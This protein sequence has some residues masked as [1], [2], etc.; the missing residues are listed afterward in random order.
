MSRLLLSI[1]GLALAVSAGAAQA[2]PFLPEDVVKEIRVSSPDIS[3]DG[4]RVVYEVT[5]ADLAKDQPVTQ[6]WIAN[7]DGSGTRQLTFREGFDHGTPKFSPDGALVGFLSSRDDEEEESRLWLLP[8]AGGEAYPLPN[9]AGSVEDF[10]F[11][12][13]GKQLALIAADPEPVLKKDSDD[14]EIPLPIVIDR[15]HFKV[16]GTGYLG[17]ERSR[18]YLYDMATGTAKRMTD[19]DFDEAFPAWS[20]DGTKVA[21]VSRRAPDPDRTPDHNIYLA[22]ADAPGTEPVRLT[23]SDWADAAPDFGSYPAWSPDGKEI[24]YVKGGDPELLW[25]AATSL[26]V[27]PA[28]GGEPRILTAGLDRNIYNPAWT[29]DGSAIRFVLED[30]GKQKLVAIPKAGG[31]LTTLVEG[32]LVVSSP[33]QSA[34]GRMA[35]LSS[36]PAVPFELFAVDGGSLRQLSRHNEAWLKEIDL[37]K[38]AYTSYKSKDG[39]EVRGFVMLPPNAERGEKLPTFLHPHGGPAMQYDYSFDSWQQVFA[40]AGYA[41]LTPNPRGSTG[42]GTT[43]SAG[44]NAAWGSVDVEDDLAA[45]DDAVAKGIADPDRLVVGGWSYGG[46]STNYLIASDTRFKA[47]MAGAGIANIFSGYGTD[48]YILEYELELGVPWDNLDVW[49]KNS[50]PFIQNTKIVTP[51][52]FMVGE[53]DVNVPT[54]A[55][56]QM[57]QALKSR[58]IDTT[59]V[60]YPDE[61]HGI[62][63]PSFQIDRMKRWLAWYAEHLKD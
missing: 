21:F 35:V 59:L 25:Y 15:Y 40:G 23:T 22:R 36:S 45:V 28:A 8:L 19:G 56:E 54:L 16:D 46:M 48:Q 32:E 55:S 20:P 33:A 17:K 26:A 44:I 58:G 4:N 43:Y 9:I 6:V 37:G 10:A 30:D 61:D 49:V 14:E 63:R 42:R 53:D 39:T 2:R 24:A 47:A 12:P 18:L 7:W 60:I 38:Q 29:T 27:I 3:P 31:A 11:S 52:M 50:Y 57:Y 1:A 62:D 13:D 34:N 5:A 41:V 51:T